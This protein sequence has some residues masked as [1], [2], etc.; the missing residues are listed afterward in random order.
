MSAIPA[1]AR[2]CRAAAPPAPVFDAS[3]AMAA[4]SERLENAVAARTGVLL[5]GEPGSGRRFL[6]GVIAARD[7]LPGPCLVL[8]CAA[9]P[10][11]DIERELFGVAAGARPNGGRQRLQAVQPPAALCQASGGTLVLLNVADLAERV[12]ARLARVLRDGD[13]VTA[14]GRRTVQIDVRPVACVE[15][16]FDGAVAEGR[17]RTDLYRALSRTRIDVPPLRARRE[18][19]PALVGYLLG[20]LCAAANVAPKCVKPAALAL[21]S[22]L[23]YPGN[24]GEL[25]GLL[26]L[27]VSR[28]DSVAIDIDELLAYLRFDGS[29]GT[30]NALASL[31]TARMRFEREYIV[32]VLRQQRGRISEAARVLEIERANL[33]RK[34]RTLR[35]RPH[36]LPRKT[37]RG[38]GPR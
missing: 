17:V 14:V 30:V 38:E 24:A 9:A 3:P 27:L 29:L 26:E 8:D 1:R 23:P 32:E 16:G 34:M 15:P 7:K 11:P 22:A 31:R 2:L 6:A 36:A 12:Q 35:I 5:V 37:A 4:V 13:A 18:D 20:E 25:R 21:L 33:Y 28:I 19:I 10:Q